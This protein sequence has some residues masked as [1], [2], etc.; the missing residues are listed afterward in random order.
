MSSFLKLVVLNE[1]GNSR[2]GGDLINAGSLKEGRFCKTK[3]PVVVD[4][5]GS[6]WHNMPLPLFQTRPTMRRIWSEMFLKP[7]NN[8]VWTSSDNFQ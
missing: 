8:T 4:G 5:D 3:C 6:H 1:K 2:V 7:E